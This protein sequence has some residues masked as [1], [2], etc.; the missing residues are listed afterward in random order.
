MT[1]NRFTISAVIFA[2]ITLAI[3]FNADAP[4]N[5]MPPIKFDI[6]EDRAADHERAMSI[7]CLTAMGHGEARSESDAGVRLVMEVALNRVDSRYYP[8]DACSVVFQKAQFSFANTSDPNR[9]KT[10][11]ALRDN[12]P[13]IQRIRKI[14]IDT[15]DRPQSERI[16]KGLHYL[17]NDARPHWRSSMPKEG[18]MRVDGHVFFASVRP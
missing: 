6:Q 15:L 13:Q 12:T 5:D 8:S 17:T 7:A 10:F 1:I 2:G 3:G 11:M 9:G 14:A 4:E 16:A 18:Q